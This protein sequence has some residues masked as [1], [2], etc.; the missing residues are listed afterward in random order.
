MLREDKVK[1]RLRE[2][3]SESLVIQ[4]KSDR[5]DMNDIGALSQPQE[6]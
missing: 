6:R 4:R 1:S 2:T 3:G 5:Q